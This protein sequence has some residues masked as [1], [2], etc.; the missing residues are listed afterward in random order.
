METLSAEALN[1]FD[2][3]GLAFGVGL[4]IAFAVEAGLPLAHHA[5]HAVIENYG[6]NREVVADRRAGFVHIHM[7][8][9]VAGDMDHALVGAGHLRTDCGAVAVTHCAKSPACQEVMR[10]CV[11]QILRRP[12]LMLTDVGDINCVFVGIFANGAHKLVRR[13][14]V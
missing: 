7:E 13:N 4:G 5:E 14:M 2:K 6:D 3:I 9:T 8:R 10:G 1:H 11:L 12:H